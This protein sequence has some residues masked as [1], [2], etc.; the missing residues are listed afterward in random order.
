[1]DPSRRTE[2]EKLA[3]ERL[4]ATAHDEEQWSYAF[5]T[6][7]AVG[8]LYCPWFVTEGW[9]FDGE[10]DELEL[11]WRPERRQ[12]IDRGG[13][14]PDEEELRQW[15][16]AKCRALADN[17][18]YSWIAWAVPVRIEGATAGYALFVS[19]PDHDP[20]D[21][22]ILDGIFDSLEEVKAALA[23]EG[24]VADER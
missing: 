1:V 4:H 13:A 11:P 3:L 22:P 24:A 7:G 6:D 17:T 5:R 18:E 8:F 9:E 23:A 2:L 14:E 19:G 20:D 10:T 21:A 15:R 12:L 16:R